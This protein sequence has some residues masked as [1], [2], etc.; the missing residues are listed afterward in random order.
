M[1]MQGRAQEHGSAQHCEI[2]TANVNLAVTPDTP[3]RPSLAHGPEN[4]INLIYILF[5]KMSAGCYTE[6]PKRFL[7]LTLTGKN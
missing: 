2:S 1:C 4:V 3:T 7:S 6:N 5:N